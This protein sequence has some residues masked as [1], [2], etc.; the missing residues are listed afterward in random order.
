VPLEPDAYTSRTRY[1]ALNRPTQLIAPHSDQP[2]TTINVIQPFYNEANLLDQVNAWVNGNVEPMVLL[3]PATANLNAV[4]NI[5]Y[6]AKGQR[7]R[8]DYGNGART[9]YTYD[10]LTFRLMHLLTRR[11]AVAFPDDCPQPPPAG[12]PG[13]QIQ[14]LHYTY[15][16]AGN[17]TH[18]RDDAQQTIY[19]KNKRVE[20]SGEYTYDAVY[21]L[22]EATGR[23]H[24]GQT[25]GVPN[26]L[27]PHSYNDAPRVGLLHPGDGNTI[28]NYLER[29]LYDAAGNFLEMQHLGSDPAHPGWTRSYDYNESSQLEAY[30]QSNRLTD[31]TIG[32]TTESYSTAGDGYDAHGN[33]LRMP[34]LQVMR[35]DFK[36]ELQ[37]T[38]RQAVNPADVDGVQHH[39]ERTW[40][41]YDSAGQRVRKVTELAT[42]QIKDE[43]V[44]LGSFEI[45]RRNGVNS[46]VRETLHIMDDQQRIALVETR[47]QGNEPGVPQQL[48]RYQFSNH[49][50][51]AS[52]ELDD[53]AQI[54]SYE[55]YTPYGSTSYQAVRIQ[56]E[57]PKRYRYT[58][59]E[60]DEENGLYYHGA[61]YFAPWLGRWMSADPAGL[62]DGANRYAYVR[63]NPL[64]FADSTGTQCDA[65]TSCV[66]DSLPTAREEALQ[67]SLPEDERHL[68]PIS[69]PDL[70]T[71]A[72]TPTLSRPAAKRKPPKLWEE[73]PRGERIPVP[74]YRG[75]VREHYTKPY[76]Q[77]F[78]DQG[79][80]EAAELAENYLCATCHVL[81]KVEPRD[82][83]LR[84]YV[85]GYQ[86]GYAQLQTMLL[87]ANPVGAGWE[88]GVSTGQAITG[89]SS[90]LHIGDLVRGNFDAGREL[91]TG[92]RLSEGGTAVVGWATLGIGSAAKPRVPSMSSSN[93][94]RGVERASDE[95][96]QAVSA[97]RTV[98]I[99]AEGSEEMRYLNAIG[100]EANVGGETM[101]HI[102]L[103]PN[104]SKAAVL[105]EFLH[106]TQHRLGIIRRLGHSGMGSAETHVKDFMIRHRRLLGLGD[107]DVARLIQ[108]RDMGL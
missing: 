21:R 94:L 5:D 36:D 35:W 54:S 26:V 83:S 75:P 57:T 41:V 56:T 38:Q 65:F 53:Q 104:P 13:C 103:R 12:C 81:T 27:T 40:Y 10:P 45:Y 79:N 66:D 93:T 100:A 102:L 89:E 62:V 108:L 82:F 17:I 55:E 43:R 22:I 32:G 48:I 28:G 8:I 95:L 107:E 23:E 72:P 47:T 97:R 69:S 24:L 30:K 71:L 34:H 2:G 64:A 37:M 18:I 52:L 6:D 105:E 84:G 63:N 98:Q 39:G 4:T 92:E 87:T 90:G 96:I 74:G 91:S 73:G 78:A 50:D 14:N 67:M 77:I 15:D 7:V 44:Y 80:Y 85:E 46:L 42:D 60:R 11:N 76:A 20:P 3:D 19:F 86:E 59:K 99:V 51:S 106:G 58:G 16:P 88:L 31:T 33:M 25:G 9:T 1:D 68:L 101:T 61:R 29:Y 49:L 70:D